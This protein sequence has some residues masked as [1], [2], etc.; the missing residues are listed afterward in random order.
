MNTALL[1]H[2]I[3]DNYI[4]NH[5]K[6]S[7][8]I[9]SNQNKKNNFNIPVK[10]VLST[11][12]NDS[13]NI[14]N[15][16]L[17][18]KNTFQKT[19]FKKTN[20][21]DTFTN[22]DEYK[23]IHRELKNLATDF[24]NSQVLSFSGSYNF[25]YIIWKYHNIA[26][27]KYIQ[28]KNLKHNDIIFVYKGG[29]F[30]SKIAKTYWEKLPD[31]AVRFLINKYRQ[32]FK[33]SDMDYSI[34]INPLLD[35]YDTIYTDIN[36]IS[37]LIQLQIKDKFLIN[38]TIYF[39]WYKQNK[40]YKQTLLDKHLT[41]F[42][43]NA[44]CFSDPDNEVYYNHTPV[45]LIFDDV[46]SKNNTQYV[47]KKKPNQIV[48]FIDR[49]N[50]IVSRTDLQTD[51]INTIYV[52]YNETIQFEKNIT[53]RSFF[54]LIRS[55]FN[56]NLVLK[57]NTTNIETL[58]NIGGELIDVSIPY[59]S[60]SSIHHFFENINEFIKPIMY[61]QP[62]KLTN[63]LVFN[64]ENESF[65]Q[66]TYSLKY[67][68]YDLH[69]V[70]F[71]QN[72]YPWDDKKYKKRLYRLFY[73]AHINFF[74]TDKIKDTNLVTLKKKKFKK[75]NF[76]FIL[77]QKI[78]FENNNSILNY[79][80]L[81]SSKKNIKKCNKQINNITKLLDKKDQLFAFDKFDNNQIVRNLRS[82]INIIIK[83]LLNYNL[84]NKELL[85]NIDIND[86]DLKKKDDSIILCLEQLQTF[87]NYVQENL[88]IIIETWKQI[89]VFCE[90]KTINA[91]I[92]SEYEFPGY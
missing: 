88:L 25:M 53:E 74:S 61:S 34:Y 77:L 82:V 7:K 24:V 28:I 90:R 12:E 86:I 68:H 56:F 79:F 52:A 21:S 33:K 81:D 62:C 64:N 17:N 87:L 65:S 31:T 55:K 15:I 10:E 42:F 23:D 16:I 32:Y 91:D 30:L 22:L 18:Q 59:R 76:Y 72:Y 29:N 14:V 47:Y 66:E 92:L 43:L 5:N 80:K 9:E 19:Y 1:L 48:D 38:P 57:N 37:F 54:N 46:S 71:Y 26:I 85:N 40:C 4:N 83:V 11:V 3:Y 45:E 89:E 39:H 2:Q 8:N 63:Y 58:H 51:N 35:N 84:I 78:L 60:D 50:K 67:L 13:I 49:K 27:N 70:L 41:E 75:I 44:S 6:L 20:K 69:A 36:Y 73:L